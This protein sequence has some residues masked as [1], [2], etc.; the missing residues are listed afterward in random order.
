MKIQLAFPIFVFFNILTIS[1]SWACEAPTVI[2][3]ENQS[4]SVIT[5]HTNASN[6]DIEYGIQ[7]FV[8]TGVP[9]VS[10]FSWVFST[11]SMPIANYI[12]FYIRKNCGTEYSV[13]VGPYSFYNYCSILNFEFAINEPFED[14]FL[15][16]CWTE[17]NLGNPEVGILG[18]N[19]SDWEQSIL[20]YN[21]SSKGARINI[22]G[23]DTNDWLVL[24]L[25]SCA[26]M[27]KSDDLGYMT[28]DILFQIALTQHES[29]L[30]ATLG[31][32]DKVQLVFSTD[33]GNTWTLINEW[34]HNS[35]ISNTG[36][37]FNVSVSA[38][39]YPN[40]ISNTFLI[41]IWANSGN[42]NDS[43]NVDFYIDNLNVFVP[44]TGSVHENLDKWGYVMCPNPTQNVLEVVSQVPMEEVIILDEK[45]SVLLRIETKS[46]TA[47]IDISSLKAGKYIVKMQ[48]AHQ[49]VVQKI[50]KF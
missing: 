49:T 46:N 30:S 21:T 47:S 34:N 37:A 13:W 22:Q 8:P 40:L 19:N 1:P 23:T 28:L 26:Y 15:P 14:A 24:P 18:L 25:L 41:G 36:Q 45:G 35:A 6:C 20:P 4:Q 32:D 38:D 39:M 27:I 11:N 17:A 16:D 43:N 33:L 9:S 50:L 12:D 7:G 48:T 42:I 29:G 3:I 44:Y 2:T 5:I 10:N 31:S